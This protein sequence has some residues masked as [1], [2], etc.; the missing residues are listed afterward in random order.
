VAKST[1]RNAE[2]TN[3]AALKGATARPTTTKSLTIKNATA[4]ARRNPKGSAN[5]KADETSPD[6]RA[7]K[8]PKAATK[9]SAAKPAGIDAG[10]ASE[11]ARTPTTELAR[12]TPRRSHVRK[13]QRTRLL[14]IV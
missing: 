3:D 5:P 4:E 14:P 10:R 11:Q 6:I 12:T 13:Y 9:Q 7:A 8:S 2:G 1:K